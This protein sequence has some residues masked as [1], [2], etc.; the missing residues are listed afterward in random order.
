VDERDP[1]ALVPG[2]STSLRDAAQRYFDAVTMLLTRPERTVL[3]IGMHRRSD[4]SRRPRKV[5]PTRWTTATHCLNT[6][7][8]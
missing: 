8:P 4:G 1:D 5:E 3:V 6:P 7:T 2:T